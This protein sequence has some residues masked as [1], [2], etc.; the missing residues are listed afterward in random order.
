AECPD[1]ALDRAGLVAGLGL[2]DVAHADWIPVRPRTALEILLDPACSVLRSLGL[3]STIR[4]LHYRII[5][6]LE[7]PGD[8]TAVD[9]LGGRALLEDQS[10][11]QRHSP[12]SVDV[13]L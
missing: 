9:V 1:A 5:H 6:E 3:G 7:V 2:Q 10:V 4:V 13:G 12:Q 8:E 11:G